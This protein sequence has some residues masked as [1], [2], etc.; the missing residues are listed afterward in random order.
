MSN[1]ITS[2]NCHAVI[3]LNN[4]KPVVNAINDYSIPHSTPFVLEAVATDADGDALS[5]N[6]EQMD[7]QTGAVMPPAGTNAGG[8]MFRSRFATAEAARYF[9]RL[10]NVVDGTSDQW[11]VLPTVGRDMDFRVTVRDHFEL[12]GC[13]EETDLTVTVVGGSGPFQITDIDQTPWLETQNVTIQWDVAGTDQAPISCTTVDIY[14]STDG[15]LT[16]PQVMATGEANDGSASIPVPL[17][18]TTTARI[19]IKCS[20]NVFYNVNDQDFVI[21]AGAPS[22]SLSA[23]PDAGVHCEDDVVT[24]T[25]A[26]QSILGYSDPVNL[27]ISGLPASATS[28]IATNPITPGSSTTISISNLQGQI[29]NYAVLVN[30]VSGSITDEVTYS[31]S[32]ISPTS[33]PALLEPA[34]MTPGTTATPTL[35]WNPTPGSSAYEY[36]VSTTPAGGNIVAS[37]TIVETEVAITN[38]SLTTQHYWRVRAVTPCGTTAW[39]SEW[40]FKTAQCA[41]F[42]AGDL[43]I[44]ISASGT[45]TIVS[46]LDVTS[47][48]TLID[49]NVVDLTGSHTWIADLNFKLIAPDATEQVFWADPCESENNFDIN[50]DDEAADSNWPCPPVDGGTYIP[51]NTLSVYDD[52][53]I[54]GEWQLEVFDDF[55]E[56]G[57]AL[58]SWGLEVCY[59]ENC[60]L[61]VDQLIYDPS[62]G[63]LQAALDCAVSGDTIFLDSAIANGTI[64]LQNQSITIDK[65]LVIIADRSDNIRIV[66]EGDGPTLTVVP[67]VA[68]ALIG[69]DL[70][71]IDGGG[72]LVSNSGQLTLEDMNFTYGQGTIPVDNQTGAQ[73]SIKGE[74]NIY[75]D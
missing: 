75:E 40:T 70:E 37:A 41:T 39:S 62:L 5:Y 67:G 36:E 60:D 44:S 57:G 49:I 23:T 47:S 58:E 34:D 42:L 19:M 2:N 4:V 28:N 72:P 50:F 31:M 51:Q 74:C 27:S 8:P 18:T 7:N 48:G 14:L 1:E 10:Q 54:E 66:A 65:D 64:N 38:L 3:A 26:A 30:G 45:P 17:G 12:P 22:F 24:F 29:G 63:S 59:T 32:V 46:S 35:K 53:E 16:F 20:D 43:P 6:W 13:T 21:E 69:F 9:P 71:N 73:L 55:N 25:L 33:A 61:T 56:D 11:E 52:I 68:V 15:G